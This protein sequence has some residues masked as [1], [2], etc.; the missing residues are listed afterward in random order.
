MCSDCLAH[1]QVSHRG[2]DLCRING[3]QVCDDD[4]L[5]ARLP[6]K[7][8]YLTE[9]QWCWW[10]EDTIKVMEPIEVGWCLR[11]QKLLPCCVEVNG[12]VG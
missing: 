11:C 5:A 10:E 6:G 4:L 7:S 8:G 3:E 2:S 9:T 12:L 1:C